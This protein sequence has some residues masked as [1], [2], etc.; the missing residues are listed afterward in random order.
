MQELMMQ[1]APL[2]AVLAILAI[3]LLLGRLLLPEERP[4]YEKRTS[5]ITDAEHHFYRVLIAAAQPRWSV[6]AMVRLADVIRVRPKAAQRQAWQN[7]I[8]AKHLDFVLCDPQTLEA[9]L[10]L[11]LDDASHQRPDRMARDEFLEAALAASSLPLLRVPVADQY[12]CDQLKKSIE[13]L[14]A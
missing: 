12:D 13:E 7:R 9:K 11:E 6:F 4:P 14:V 8:L 1:Y 2:L 10:A 3:A 5:L